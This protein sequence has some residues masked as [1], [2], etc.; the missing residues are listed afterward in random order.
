MTTVDN[1]TR[2]AYLLS[3]VRTIS[4][5]GLPPSPPRRRVSGGW[6]VYLP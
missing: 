1:P 3:R 5:A 4:V 6:I 2:P